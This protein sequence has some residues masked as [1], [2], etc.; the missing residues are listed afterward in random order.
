MLSGLY[1]RRAA[2][3]GMILP[4]TAVFVSPGICA[5]SN[6]RVYTKCASKHNYPA[7]GR[8]ARVKAAWKQVEIAS[9][10]R[11]YTKC[12]SNTITQP[13]DAARRKKSPETHVKH[14]GKMQ[15]TIVK[16]PNV[17]ISARRKCRNRNREDIVNRRSGK[18]RERRLKR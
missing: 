13:L 5:A 16:Y 4:D 10:G 9:N 14:G 11:V 8:R 2:V 7:V 12:A 18:Y 3:S 6:G 17:Y 1:E 15:Y